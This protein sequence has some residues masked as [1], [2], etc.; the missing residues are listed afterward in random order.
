[1]GSGLR[2]SWLSSMLGKLKDSLWE[3]AGNRTKAMLST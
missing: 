3:Y 2:V 1:M